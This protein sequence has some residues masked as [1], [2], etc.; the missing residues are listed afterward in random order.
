MSLSFAICRP[1]SAALEIDSKTLEQKGQKYRRADVLIFL[2]IEKKI[3]KDK[4]KTLE[5]K[6]EIDPYGIDLHKVSLKIR[7]ISDRA[8]DGAYIKQPLWGVSIVSEAVNARRIISRSPLI[9]ESMVLYITDMSTGDFK[10]SL[11]TLLP[12]EEIEVSYLLKGK[13][14]RKPTVEGNTTLVRKRTERVY[15]LVAKYTFLFPYGRTKT[16]DVN[17]ENIKELLEGFR[18]AGL[19]PMVKIVGTADGVRRSDR[20]N[21]EVAKRR[22]TFV[23]REIFGEKYACLLRSRFAESR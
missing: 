17:L 9:F 10:L 11:P 23:A 15:M 7:N 22:A 14:P 1:S 20:K 2:P 12:G 18:R 13:P 21:R 16:R 4:L 19:K 6:T 5:V 8:V 3:L